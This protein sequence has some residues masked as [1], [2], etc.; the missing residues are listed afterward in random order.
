MVEGLVKDVMGLCYLTFF[1]F[2]SL[3]LAFYL[4]TPPCLPDKC[5]SLKSCLLF[6]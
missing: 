6:D 2:F 3:P 5:A 1:P 4:G